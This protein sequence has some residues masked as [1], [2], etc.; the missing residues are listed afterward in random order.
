MILWLMLL[1]YSTANED[2]LM[3]G[4]LLGLS[5]HQC[6][7]I[8]PRD[9]RSNIFPVS[10]DFLKLFTYLFIEFVTS[11]EQLMNNGISIVLA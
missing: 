6:R 5:S 7:L 8:L 1:Q 4:I 10:D 2:D 3:A 9:A 11:I